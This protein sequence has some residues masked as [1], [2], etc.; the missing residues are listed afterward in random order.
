VKPNTSKWNYGMDGIGYFG[1]QCDEHGVPVRRTKITNPYNYD[2][3]V[4]WR[5]GSNSEA[6][7]TIYSDRLY[8]WDYKKYNLLCLKHFGNKGQY[9]DD[10]DSKKIEAFLRDYTECPSLRLILVMEYCNQSTGYPCWRF[11][12]TFDEE[13]TA[14]EDG[15]KGEGTGILKS[16]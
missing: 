2:G 8:Q 3:F 16:N 6:K 4:V 5:G 11:D 14:A 7:D 9:W 12:Y 1:L 15:L 13:E 10:R